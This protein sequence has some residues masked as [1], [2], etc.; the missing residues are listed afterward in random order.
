MS[1]QNTNEPIAAPLSA[2]F[3]HSNARVHAS[4]VACPHFSGY[5]TKGRT[6][7]QAEYHGS[8][9]V[10]EAIFPSARADPPRTVRY[11]WGGGMASE[12]EDGAPALDRATLT[13]HALP[14]VDHLVRTLALLPAATPADLA[15]G[16]PDQP[17]RMAGVL[18]PVYA[19]DGEPYLLFTRRSP[20]LSTHS[21]QISFP[22][23]S[24]D[25][26]DATLADTALREAHEELGIPP[27]RVRVLGSLTPVFTVVSNFLITPVVGWM[28]DDRIS[29]APNPH[30]VAEVIEAPLAALADPGIFHEEDWVRAGRPHAVYFYDHGA[31]RIWGATA[32]ILHELLALLPS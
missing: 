29:L 15:L 6:A 20:T 3:P 2:N 14:L 4:R 26:G 25:P 18:V 19:R 27:E 9:E 11:L 7:M 31:Y 13:T 32:R 23:G 8:P 1:V 12:R 10:R 5:Y 17:P 22:G 30:E 21:G 16:P 28:G 24:R